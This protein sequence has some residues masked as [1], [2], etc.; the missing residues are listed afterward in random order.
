MGDPTE[1]GNRIRRVA[2]NTGPI[3][4]LSEARTLDLLGAMG[5]V[6][7]PNAVDAEVAQWDA[8]WETQRPEW[9]HVEALIPPQDARAAAWWQAGLLGAGEAEAIALAQ[10]MQANWLLT[11]DA[12]ARLFAQS[13]GIEAHG[14]L[15][16]VLWAAASAH[17]DRAGARSAIHRLA[18]SSL[19]V[20]ARVLAEAK[21]AVERLFA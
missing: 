6:H 11:D 5:E 7:I 10:Q 3:V 2:S 15:G 17:I 9:I 16:V 8:L 19:W 14:S 13:L 20:S 12:A 21:A 1:R 4:H 18:H